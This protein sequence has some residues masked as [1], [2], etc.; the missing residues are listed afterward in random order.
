MKYFLLPFAI[1]I[2]TTVFATGKAPPLRVGI[3]DSGI[4]FSDKQTMDHLCPGDSL[5]DAVGYGM[6]DHTGHGSMI[7]KIITDTA[8]DEADYCLVIAK[9]LHIEYT[10]TKGF[11]E[12]DPI[13]MGLKWILNQ[14]VSLVNM[15]LQMTYRNDHLYNLMRNYHDVKF[16]V[17]SGN[18]KADIDS[19]TY[20]Y[21]P[22]FFLSNIIAVGNLIEDPLSGLII[23]DPESNYGS[24]VRSWEFGTRWGNKSKYGCDYA[25]ATS[26]A[27]AIHTG[28]MIRR[29]RNEYVLP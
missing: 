12:E 29:V 28:K 24:V 14:D 4:D 22:R 21:P 26:Q 19:T 3:L 11:E 2:S 20:A 16:I 8:G 5:F 10:D 15:S 1:C 18:R 13:Y 9:W 17:A 25:P 27:A 23:H 7:N 6:D